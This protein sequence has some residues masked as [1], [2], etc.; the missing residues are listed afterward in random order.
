MREAVCIDYLNEPRAIQPDSLGRRKLIYVDNCASHNDSTQA[1]LTTDRLNMEIR[2]LPANAT[3]L[4][5]LAD[6]FVF[7]NQRCMDSTLGSPQ[8][9]MCP[10][11]TL[12]R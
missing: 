3:D 2:K 10:E 5:Q 7:K 8:I 12:A 6:S 1:F 4:C 11:W 9:A